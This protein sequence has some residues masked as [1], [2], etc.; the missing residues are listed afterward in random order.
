M[1]ELNDK[2]EAGWDWSSQVAVNVVVVIADWMQSMY[3]ERER[4][5][6]LTTHS[7]IDKI[8]NTHNEGMILDQLNKYIQKIIMMT[9]WLSMRKE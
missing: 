4:D 1:S 2:Y 3:I 5:K 8:G 9:K 7:E 6:G